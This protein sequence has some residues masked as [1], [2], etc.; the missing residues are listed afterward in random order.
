[1]NKVITLTSG[2]ASTLITYLLMTTNHRK[3]EREAWERLATET[4]PDGSPKFPN[5][6]SNARY[7][8]E[9]ELELEAIRKAIDDAPLLG[10]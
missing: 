1:M 4:K 10:E 3:G 7:F 2:Q 8:A 5:A 9:L 6:P